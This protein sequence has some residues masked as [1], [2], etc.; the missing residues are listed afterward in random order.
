[1]IDKSTY[2]TET[3]I[4]IIEDSVSEQVSLLKKALEDK[5]NFKIK[6]RNILIVKEVDD[7]VDE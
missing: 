1:M 7:D 3:E 2:V 5:S 6:K 4:K